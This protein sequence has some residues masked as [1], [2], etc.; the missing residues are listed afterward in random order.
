MIRFRQKEFIAPIIAALA[1]AVIQAAG[2][3]AQQQQANKSQES[4][5]RQQQVQAIKDRKAQEKQADQQRKFEDKQLKV[6]QKQQNQMVKLAKQNPQAAA[7]IKPTVTV[8]QTSEQAKTFSKAGAVLNGIANVGI[9]ALESGTINTALTMKMNRDQMKSNERIAAKE[10]RSRQLEAAA[11]LAES[12]NKTAIEM[13]KLSNQKNEFDKSY[14]LVRRQQRV[15]SNA[16]KEGAGFVKNLGTIA[17]GRGL[18][19]VLASAAV[20]GAVSGTG[21]YLVDKA[22]Q[23]DAKKSGIL[24]IEKPELT[25]EEKAAKKKKRNRK[26]VI[27]AGTGAL[28]AGGTIAAKKGKLGSDMKKAV[29]KVTSR[30]I[31]DKTKS[32]VNTVKEATKDY[33]APVDERTG[34][35][36]VD[37]LNL[38]LIGISTAAPAVTYLQKKKLVKD[39]IKQSEIDNNESAKEKEKAYSIKINTKK[40]KSGLNKAASAVEKQFFKGRSKNKHEGTGSDIADIALKARTSK[41]YAPKGRT[42]RYKVK[43]WIHKLK[44]KPGETLLDTLSFR[45]GGGGKQGVLGFGD[46]L[47]KLGKST[48][49]KTSQKIGKYIKE[50]DKAAMLGSAAVGFGVIRKAKNK[51][52]ELGSKSIEKMDPNAYA[53]AKYGAQVIPQEEKEDE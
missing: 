43:D 17:K 50:H 52:Y 15:Y 41:L 24:K 45:T 3:L 35:R 14:R 1:P 7:A 12:K 46:D 19:K 21:S 51:M 30:A 31:K 23:K 28:L 44:D 53:Y 22:I 37:K 13:Q 10:N 9:G 38:A 20:A 39:Q 18:P 8:G 49:N 48:G 34:K 36:R 40:I 32:G 25:K 47:E 11:R 29:S 42:E 4:I 5:A 27:A 6:A 33:F 16:V 26:L 2:G